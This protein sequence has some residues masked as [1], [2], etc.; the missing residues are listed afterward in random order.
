[1]ATPRRPPPLAL[2]NSPS[3]GTARVR[4]FFG[5]GLR[6]KRLAEVLHDLPGRHRPAHEV[7]LHLVAAQ[8]ITVG[9]HQLLADE[10]IALG[11]TDTGPDPYGLLIA[12]LGACTSMTISLYARRKQWSLEAMTVTPRHSKIHAAD[13]T[14]CGAMPSHVGGA[15]RIG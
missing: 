12:A 7:T 5:P 3:P 15:T 10:P 6:D 1:M 9:R 8:Q 2:G 4:A 14:D 11:G 13:C